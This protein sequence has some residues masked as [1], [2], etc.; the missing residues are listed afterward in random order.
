VA[1][2]ARW[3]LGSPPGARRKFHD[4]RL[5][6]PGLCHHALAQIQLLYQIERDADA[7]AGGGGDRKLDAVARQTL[8]E[9]H[10][11]PII[12]ALVAWCEQQQR[13][14]LP[15]SG[16]GEALTYTL[17]QIASLRRYLDDG[18]LAIDNNQCERSM[19]PIAI[20]RKNWLFTGSPAGGKAA[21]AMFSLISSAKR[22]H[23]E[24]LAYLTD[25]FTRLPA[26]PISQLTQFLPDHW[27]P[28][29]I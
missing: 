9:T 25:L 20:G 27:Q 15:K 24:P 29:P 16:L 28:R 3:L 10:A 1:H 6:S 19:R 26:T 13:Q 21:A 23:V 22:H 14:A 8:R 4:A 17:N 11:R 5:Q 2:D 12:D 18:Q 7:D